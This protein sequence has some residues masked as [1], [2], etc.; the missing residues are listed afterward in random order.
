MSWVLTGT[1]FEHCPCDMV[2]PC[3]TSRLSKPADTEPCTVVLAFNIQRGQIEGLDVAS[4]TV[5]LVADAPQLMSDGV[6]KS[7]CTWTM[8]PRMISSRH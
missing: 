7:A 8:A 3:T 5:V 2:C 1:Y 4:R 6:G